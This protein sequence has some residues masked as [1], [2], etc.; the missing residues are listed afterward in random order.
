VNIL[1]VEDEEDIR[2]LVRFWLAEDPRCSQVVEADGPMTAVRECS[3]H[4][5]DVILVAFKIAGGTAADCL[6]RLRSEHPGARIIVYTASLPVAHQANVL[7]LGADLVVEQIR[8]V[9]DVVDLV[10]SPMAH[11]SSG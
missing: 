1:V 4:T 2:F 8:V 9:E 3:R 6:P 11:T 5:L 10:L 7:A